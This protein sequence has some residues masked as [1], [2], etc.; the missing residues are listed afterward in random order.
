MPYYLFNIQPAPPPVNK[1]LTLLNE[2]EKFKVA[3]LEVRQLRENNTDPKTEFKIVF[4]DNLLDAE[5]KLMEKR[6]APFLAEWER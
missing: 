4:A 5:E 2:Y 3:K 1:N 6:E